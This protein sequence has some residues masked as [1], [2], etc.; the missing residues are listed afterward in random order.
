MLPVKDF[1]LRASGLPLSYC[2]ECGIVKGRVRYRINGKKKRTNKRPW[3]P[4]KRERS[5]AKLNSAVRQKKV[6][7]Q[8][9]EVCGEK[10][11][12]HH[13]DYDQPLNVRWLCSIHHGMEHWKPVSTP[14]L[15]EAKRQIATA[16]RAR[17]GGL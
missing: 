2:K 4:G 17:K 14:I 10:A 3:N 7:R 1:G 6:K 8:P 5:E 13:P 12:A 15:E 9:C 11:Q 16:I